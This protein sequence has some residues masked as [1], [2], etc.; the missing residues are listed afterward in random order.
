MRSSEH[1]TPSR[2]TC[3]SRPFTSLQPPLHWVVSLLPST[4]CSA[5]ASWESSS[6]DDRLILSFTVMLISEHYE[7]ALQ[8]ECPCETSRSRSS[9]G[10]TS[11]CWKGQSG[12]MPELRNG[13]HSYAGNESGSPRE[14][15]LRSAKRRV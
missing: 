9:V 6:I 7:V 8:V 13:C 10:F 5:I 11:R 1:C 14:A 4:G 3:A 12:D 15:H 2:R